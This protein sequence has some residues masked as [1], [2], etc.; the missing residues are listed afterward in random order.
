MNLTLVGLVATAISYWLF[1]TLAI[2]HVGP[3]MNRRPLV[4]ALS[5]P[6]WVH[7]FRHIALQIFSAQHFGFGISD[8][9]AA[10][11]AWGDV[12]G[13]CLALVG[14]WLLHLRSSA[15][16]IVIW[17]FVVE[18]VVDLANATFIGI[19]EEAFS[20]AHDVTWLI[21]TFYV[22]ALWTSLAL[23]VWQLVARA[24]KGSHWTTSARPSAPDVEELTGSKWPCG[25]IRQRESGPAA[26]LVLRA[27]NVV[28]HAH[29]RR[30]G[31]LV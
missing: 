5:V 11:I 15:A 1:I 7:A 9:A 18:T 6:L 8:M 4:V 2:Q 14:L 30:P 20:T 21:L 23:L 10:Q 19:G 13:A 27:E 28:G 31:C 29:G 17:L 16:R 26:A 12:A 24:W 3:W 22:P 25:V